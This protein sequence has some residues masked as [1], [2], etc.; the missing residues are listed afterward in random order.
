MGYPI[1]YQLTDEQKT[2]ILDNHEKMY[3]HEISEKLQVDQKKIRRFIKAKQLRVKRFFR[4]VKGPREMSINGIFNV[5]F[6]RGEYSW[7]M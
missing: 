7:I 5:D 1:D 3:V 6:Y 2:F 4:A